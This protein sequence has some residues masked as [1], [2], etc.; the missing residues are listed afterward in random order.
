M[1]RLVA[2]LV[3]G[4]L[5][6]A[7]VAVLSSDQ[8]EP[9]PPPSEEGDVA[10]STPFVS[11]AECRDC[12][13]DVYDE[14][15]SSYHGQAWTD[16]MVQ[17]LS[18]GFTQSECIDCHAPQPIHVTGVEH[19]VA[20]RGH[21][22]TDGVDCLTCHLLEDG[23]S[24]AAAATADTT[25]TKGACRPR[26]VPVMTESTACASC[27]NQHETVDEVLASGRNETCQTCH[28]PEVARSGD[29]GAHSGRSH[30]FPGAHSEEMHRKATTM[31]VRVADGKIH[32]DVTN[33]GG[34]HHI[35]TDARHRSYNVWITLVDARGNPW[36]PAWQQMG[37][38]EYRLYY[39]DDFKES[40]QIANGQ[41]RTATFDVPSG[42]KGTA[43]VRLTYALNPED[44]GLRVLT[45]VHEQEI[46]IP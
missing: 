41:T 44:L 40:T 36:T 39:R 45:N 4:G 6:A 32:A 1:K 9:P 24:V 43:T 38:G 3:L 31:A 8:N 29:D 28:M 33:S 13:T 42:F 15:R 7:G 12:H 37:D 21:N 11:A 35:P 23:V 19:R 16:P 46:Q 25:R 14:W 22:R 34:A 30:R 17:A 2:V 18:G 20:P 10:R 5:V 27:H 26:E